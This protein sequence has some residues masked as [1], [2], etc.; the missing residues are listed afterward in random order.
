MERVAVNIDRFGNT[1]AT[2]IPVARD[3][4]LAGGRVSR[5]DYVML[6]GF[7]TGL[8]WGGNLLCL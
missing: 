3:E 5:G 6:V 7:G 4:A 8:S 1:I 2:S